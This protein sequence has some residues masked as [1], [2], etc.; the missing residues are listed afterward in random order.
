MGAVFAIFAGFYFWAPKIIGK[1]YNELLGKI[2][3]WT[4]FVGVNTTFFPQHFLGLAGKLY[5]KYFN[6]IRN[7]LKLFFIP[8]T[9]YYL[10]YFTDNNLVIFGVF[11]G[12]V[13]ILGYLFIIHRLWRIIIYFNKRFSN[14]SCKF[15]IKVQ[16]Y[17]RIFRILTILFILLKFIWIYNLLF[18]SFCISTVILLGFAFFRHRRAF[19]KCA[20]LSLI[21]NSQT[22]KITVFPNRSVRVV[23]NVNIVECKLEFN[24]ST[25]KIQ[26]ISEEFGPNIINNVIIGQNAHQIV[27]THVMPL[28]ESSQMHSL[29]LEIFNPF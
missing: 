16:Q 8:L 7:I 29:F 28:I 2:H 9:L 20:A 22:N 4:L 1:S 23:D 17:F 26:E 5:K 11:T 3:F 24:I 18:Y 21:I 12:T 19:A 15:I 13:S 14:L 25:D 27:E 6:K 10:N